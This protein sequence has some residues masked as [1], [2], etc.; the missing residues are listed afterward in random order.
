VVKIDNHA[1]ARPQTGLNQADVVYEEE[2]EGITRF[3]AVFQSGNSTPVGPIRSARTTDV[4]LVAA[5]S[6]PL[7]AWSGGNP[8]VQR[9]IGGADLTDVGQG[10][11]NA[12]GGYHRDNRTNA[13]GSEHT[14]YADTVALYTLTPAG[15]GA[16]AP[17]FPFR[18]DN[19]PSP[20]GDPIGGV[21]LKLES[22]KAQ[23]LWDA[24][25]KTWLRDENG[26]P[27]VDY[28]GVQIAPANV[29]IQF[30]SYVG[31]PGV[32][33]SQQAVTV[34][35]GEAWILTD[36]KIVKGTWSRPDPKQPAV[37]KDA[38]GNP[39]K[40]TPGRTW[41]ELPEPGGAVEIPVGAE[42]DSVPF[43]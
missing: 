8:T 31:V 35:E 41:V 7:F 34:G 5:L 24:A 32:G 17:L 23:F 21:R 36:G 15:Q 10:Q 33:Q 12:P 25:S 42:P 40:L 3:F 14:L 37:Y 1:E 19:E 20:V 4:N 29:V 30:V 26:S 27:H 16:P 9:Q 18:G 28:D 11:A 39:V 13:K 43:P 22:T 38:A 6:H 2:V